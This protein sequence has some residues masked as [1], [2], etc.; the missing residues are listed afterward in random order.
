VTPVEPPADA[1]RYAYLALKADAHVST[2]DGPVLVRKGDYGRFRRDVRG[3]VV[4][5][6]TE[7]A[8]QP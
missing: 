6:G 1:T 4:D 5:D 8:C 2:A 7:V 3:W